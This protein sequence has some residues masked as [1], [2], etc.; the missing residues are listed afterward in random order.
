MNDRFPKATTV[1]HRLR[2]KASPLALAAHLAMV[3]LTA[4]VT[5]A[6][7]A[8]AADT[9]ATYDIPAGA[10]NA[11]IHRFV[12]QSGV[13]VAADGALT[14]GRSSPGLRGRH[15]PAEALDRLL[16]GTGLEAV[17][18]VD[19]SYALRKAPPAP[20]KTEAAVPVKEA[21]LP[22]VTVKAA[23]ERETATGPVAGYGAKRSATATKTD[24][25]IL[26]TP[27]SISVIGAEQIADQKATSLTEALAYTPGVMADPGYANSY[28][29][30]YSR[31]FRLQD[32]SGSVYR[33]GLKLGGSGWATGQQ[34]PYGLE[35]VELLKGAASVLF[36]AAAPGG[37]L[38]VVTKQPQPGQVN[39]VVGEVGN[40]SHR[41]FAA[42]LG[43]ALSG[44]V[45]GRVVLLARD[46]DTAVDHIPNN[47][48][49][50]APSLR[51]T[52]SRDTSLTLLAHYT[53]RRTA[54]I[55][56]VPVEGSLLPSPYGKLPRERF[57]GEPGFDRQ[58]TRQS[59]F[60]WVLSHQIA[61]G[62]KLHHGLRWID[63]ENHVRFTNL[64]SRATTDPRNFQRRAIDELETSRG[65]SADTNVQAEFDAGGLR[66]KAIAGF[67]IARH[68][69]GSVWELASLG[70]LN[71]FD[72]VYGASPGTFAP[73][74]NDQDKQR[75]VGLY[76]QDQ[77]KA[78][79]LTVLAGVR[80]DEVRSELNGESEKTGATTGRLGMVWE[81]APGIA[82]FASWSQSFEP[83]SG[84][85]ND[86]ERYKPTRGGQLELGV[87]WQR[88]EFI[89]S[90]A[91]F[92]LVQKNVLKN[93]DALDK[94]VQTGEVRSRGLE[95]EAKGPVARNVQLIASYAYTNAKVTKSEDAAEI[96]QPVSY[97]PRHQAALWTRVDNWLVPGLHAGLGAR[98]TGST[99]D[100]GGTGARVPAYTTLDAL[101][102][103]TTGPWTLR[104]NANNLTDK[105]TLLC[106][107]GWCTYGDGL[108]AT[109]SVAYRW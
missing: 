27:Q 87:R 52:P 85:G 99:A 46:A 32:G 98:H 95:I 36:G 58:D 48:R 96:G 73:L 63:S 43:G 18:Q 25:P 75:R 23:A 40:Y 31:G 45:A 93:R 39:E 77:V 50:I 44:D 68:H 28:D 16:A 34:E 62:V 5:L 41:A 83:V 1:P 106:N 100:W 82:P 84:T 67:D 6:P 57:V 38:N 9:L 20:A 42:D 69:I 26:E 64:N 12:A 108:R 13:F 53:E 60:G 11:A 49:Y 104:L 8:H 79:A 15:A 94:A 109:A 56:G 91:A 24:T 14:E 17:R 54:Y 97:Q 86:G 78:G 103:Y 2:R 71:L 81:V 80:R 70:P 90:V 29:V 76:L 88:G 101:V 51:W 102:G 7:P 4:A 3:G 105:T 37:V 55:W 22:A 92:D 21:V 72:P 10:L 30:F 35:R 107:G 74:F 61:E 89:A 33:D 19:G 66:H 65:V 47:A 59:S